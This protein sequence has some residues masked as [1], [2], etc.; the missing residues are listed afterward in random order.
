MGAVGGWD[1]RGDPVVGTGRLVFR[2][3]VGQLLPSLE[4]GRAD[5]QHG[6]LGLHF[7]E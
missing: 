6:V 5:V 7:R 2:R 3:R 4:R 1:H